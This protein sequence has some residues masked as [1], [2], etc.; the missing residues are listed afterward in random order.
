MEIDLMTQLIFAMAEFIFGL[1]EVLREKREKSRTRKNNSKKKI[2]CSMVMRKTSDKSP[3]R[4]ILQK[5]QYSS[6]LS[7]EHPK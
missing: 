7:K 3:Q 2:H 5:Y 1:S 6:K 4:N